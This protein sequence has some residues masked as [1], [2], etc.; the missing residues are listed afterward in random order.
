[1]RLVDFLS[2]LGMCIFAGIMF[3]YMG[4]GLALTIVAAFILFLLSLSALNYLNGGIFFPVFF[5]SL[6]KKEIDSE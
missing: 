5:P 6:P 2:I 4:M 1:M 3:F